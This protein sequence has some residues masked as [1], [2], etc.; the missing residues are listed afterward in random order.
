[1]DV[2][3][4]EGQTVGYLKLVKDFQSSSISFQGMT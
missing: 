3:S 4:K 2:V 1:M